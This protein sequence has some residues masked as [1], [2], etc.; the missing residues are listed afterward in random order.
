MWVHDEFGDAT[1]LFVVS[2]YSDLDEEVEKAIQ[3]AVRSF[4]KYDWP[5]E[6]SSMSVDPSQGGNRLNKDEVESGDVSHERG[7]APSEAAGETESIKTE[8]ARRKISDEL[9]ENLGSAEPIERNSQE[10]GS[11][12]LTL[13]FRSSKEEET[14]KS[15]LENEP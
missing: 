5:A 15:L 8:A 13:A 3:T 1:E 9:S 2:K 7:E 4:N 12:Q 6:D 10:E 11:F 14:V